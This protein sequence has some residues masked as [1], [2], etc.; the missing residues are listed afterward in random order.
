MKNTPQEIGS[1]P[2]SKNDVRELILE[3][4][5]SLIDHT[6]L[7][8][9]KKVQDVAE[10]VEMIA[11]QLSRSIERAP[12]EK[13]GATCEE[14]VISLFDQSRN[15]VEPWDKAGFT[16]YCVD[17][18]HAPGETHWK[19]AIYRCR[20]SRLARSVCIGKDFLRFPSRAQTLL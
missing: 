12:T 13:E 7:E 16:C 10:D 3:P 17:V 20:H 14:I 4:L 19:H 11:R 6:R 18:E 15:I 9:L 2:V 8:I 5:S 1:G